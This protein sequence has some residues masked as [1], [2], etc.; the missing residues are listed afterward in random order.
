MRRIVIVCGFIG[1]TRI[2]KFTSPF[3]ASAWRYV[4]QHFR[5]DGTF[6][7]RLIRL[8]DRFTT[9]LTRVFRTRDRLNAKHGL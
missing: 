6:V 5:L 7:M 2:V 8:F 9:F 3:R 1:R 4:A